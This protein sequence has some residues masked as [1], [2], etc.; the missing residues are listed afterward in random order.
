M[1]IRKATK[2]DFKQLA[3]I[4]KDEYKR[5]FKEK[6]TDQSALRLITHFSKIAMSY[7]A[8]IDK[9]AVGFIIGRLEPRETSWAMVV[10][11][12][13]VDKKYQ[14]KGIGKALILKI[15]QYARSKKAHLIYLTTSKKAPAAKFYSKMKYKPAKN[16][17]IFGKR[18]R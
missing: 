4:A 15:E 8:E 13:A 5:T 12:L 11:E 9:K 7:V 18:L 3:Q 10:E 17:I 14:Q 2:K 1:K 16:V 6:Y